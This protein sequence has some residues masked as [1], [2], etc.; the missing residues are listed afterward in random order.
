MINSWVCAL[1]AGTALNAARA[2]R[3]ASSQAVQELT[4]R[5]N[6][7]RQKAMKAQ[8]FYEPIDL[9]SLKTKEPKYG[10]LKYGGID[11]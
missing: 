10:D 6:P 9:D 1:V 2:Q 3:K 8:E 5:L 7:N 4:K 11:G